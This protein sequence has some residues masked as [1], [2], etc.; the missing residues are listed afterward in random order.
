[1]VRPITAA[2]DDLEQRLRREINRQGRQ[3]RQEQK[4]EEPSDREDAAARAVI[5]AAI[6]VHRELGPGLLESIYEAAM[7]VELELRDIPY[8]RQVPISVTYKGEKIGEH[9]LD[10]IVDEV[11]IVELKAT[12]AFEPVHTAQLVSYL[13]AADLRLGLLLNF[14]LRFLRDGIRRVVF[15]PYLGGLGGVGG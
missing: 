15:N 5:G 3:G 14:N 1:M 10:L 13:R 2:M 12:T 9:R 6:E 11:L 8:R 4:K 7:A